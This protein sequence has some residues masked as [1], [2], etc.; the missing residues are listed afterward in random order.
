M[1]FLSGFGGSGEGAMGREQLATDIWRAC[2]IMRRDNNCG[3]VMEYLEH[4][5]WLLFLRFLDEQEAIF[6]AEG[7]LAQRKYTRILAGPYRW[8]KWVKSALGQK[9]EKTGKSRS[10]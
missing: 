8:S 2:D 6:E 4:L 5:S 10:P 7:S 3:G 9:D 1:S